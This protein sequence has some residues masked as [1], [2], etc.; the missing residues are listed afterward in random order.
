MRL[1]RQ[2]SKY[3]PEQL[4]SEPKLGGSVRC[5]RPRLASQR[6]S[7]RGSLLPLLGIKWAAI[8]ANTKTK[9]QILGSA[10]ATVDNADRFKAQQQEPVIPRGILH[11]FSTFR[12]LW[13]LLSIFLI[14]FIAISLPYRLA[15]PVTDSLAQIVLDFVIDV[16]FVVDIFVNFRTAYYN[17]GDLICSQCAIARR[18]VQTWFVLDVSSSLPIE[19]FLIREDGW[20]FRS[21]IA[22]ATNTTLIDGGGGRTAAQLASILKTFKIL[23]LLKLLRLARLLRYFSGLQ[24]Y[25][26]DH[27][28]WLNSNVLRLFKLT[29]VFFLACHWN[30]CIQFFMAGLSDY[31]AESWV[32]RGGLIGEAGV[33]L[34]GVSLSDQYTYAYFCAGSQMLA[35]DA[36]NGGIVP[37]VMH[38]ELVGNLLSIM[39]GSLL[40]AVLVASLTSVIAE[41][42]PAARAYRH[43]VDTVNHYMR[44]QRLPS[45]LRAKIREYLELAF[46][47]KCSFDEDS[48]LNEL[49]APLRQEVHLH[50]CAHVL[51]TLHVI[52]AGGDPGMPGAIAAALQHVVFVVDDYIL[53]EGT[54][55]DGMYFLSGGTVDVVQGQ[56]ANERVITSLSAGSFFGE[57]ALLSNTGR[58]MASI[59][60]S[61]SCEGHFLS[62]KRYMDLIAS[63]RAI[64]VLRSVGESLWERW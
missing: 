12:L 17:D 3:M 56:G 34:D 51:N 6:F 24:V 14:S 8:L 15:F 54:R 35:L 50:K 41:S 11:P 58:A 33:M 18:Y 27:F 20:I 38:H 59:R 53:R 31:P 44:Y 39:I 21:A 4:Q 45:G 48:I 64:R 22:E 10:L 13:D 5:A 37:P 61:T 9:E 52:H 55:P 49:T 62:R 63:S 46:P 57:M 25:I 29:V 47:A 36:W 2:F 60:V 43:K 16:Y 32:V 42:D 40:Y 28:A 30:A 1:S 19:W 23:K 7:R 26:S